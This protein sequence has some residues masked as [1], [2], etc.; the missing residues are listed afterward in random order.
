[1]WKILPGT[2]ASTLFKRETNSN[3]NNAERR[4]NCER[5][6]EQGKTQKTNWNLYLN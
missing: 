2:K 4:I 3:G 1:M 6:Y 5:G